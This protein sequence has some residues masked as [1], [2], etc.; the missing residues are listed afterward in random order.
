MGLKFGDVVV[1]AGD[2]LVV[3]FLGHGLIVQIAPRELLGE[4]LVENGVLIVHDGLMD[5]ALGKSTRGDVLT[6]PFFHKRLHALLTAERKQLG[7]DVVI[8]LKTI[9]SACGVEDPVSDIDHIQQPPE[10]FFCQLDVHDARLLSIK[11]AAGAGCT[12]R[13]DSILLYTPT[14]NFSTAKFSF[15]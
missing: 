15:A 4:D 9:V 2:Q 14:R 3:V 8:V 13:N 11:A 10:F 7:F 12:G 1:H 6:L 5:A